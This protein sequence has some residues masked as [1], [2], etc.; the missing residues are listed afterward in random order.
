MLFIEFL[1][2]SDAN[3]VEALTVMTNVITRLQEEVTKSNS[4][5]TERDLMIAGLNQQISDLLIKNQQLMERNADL[6]AL[7]TSPGKADVSLNINAESYT[8]VSSP[9]NSMCWS[10]V[11]VEDASD[12]PVEDA[13]DDQKDTSYAGVIVPDSNGSVEHKKEFV[14]EKFVVQRRPNKPCY[15]FGARHKGK[16]GIVYSGKCMW[17]FLGVDPTFFAYF[18]K[19]MAEHTVNPNNTK[20]PYIADM[21]EECSD[22]ERLDA[23]INDRFIVFTIL[24]YMHCHGEIED[25]RHH[26]PVEQLNN[27]FNAMTHKNNVVPLFGMAK[28]YFPDQFTFE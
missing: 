5:I 22:L 27:V 21:F 14:Y 17:K 10:D 16:T 18:V 11:P 12:A 8:P 6:S 3:Y 2:M 23:N 19:K 28:Q 1:K 7:I 4:A 15:L 25:Y 24:V 9:T 13:S 20:K 26:T